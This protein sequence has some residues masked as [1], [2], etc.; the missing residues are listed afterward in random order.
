M[1]HVNIGLET[2]NLSLIKRRNF[3]TVN[4]SLIDSL[5]E[6]VAYLRKEKYN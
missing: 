6:E 4:V 5:K 3:V 2:W 1:Q